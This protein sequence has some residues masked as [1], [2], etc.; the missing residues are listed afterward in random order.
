MDGTS[1][2]RRLSR[3]RTVEYGGSIVDRGGGQRS[4]GLF[5]EQGA[6]PY[7]GELGDLAVRA[8]LE[9][10]RADGNWLAVCAPF[11][12]AALAGAGHVPDRCPGV[13]QAGQGAPQVAHDGRLAAE[14]GPQ[15]HVLK[16]RVVAEQLASAVGVAS[17][18]R[19]GELPGCCR[20]R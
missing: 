4:D 20:D 17:R 19:G 7:D 12:P 2:E 5:V 8:E 10:G 15:R 13:G 18:E 3:R 1:G 16:D 9:P 14:L 6:V 11:V